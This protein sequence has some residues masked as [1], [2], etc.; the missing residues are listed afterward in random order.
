MKE[1]TGEYENILYFN[2]TKN[3]TLALL[4]A[5]N[6]V[7]FFVETDDVKKQRHFNVP[8]TF[9]NYEKS[10]VIEDLN[11][12]EIT[13]LNFNHL[14]RLVLSFEGITKNAERQTQKY[15]KFSKLIP[16][17][18]SHEKAQFAYN[19]L[20]Y[21]FSFKLLLQTRG[22][23]AATQIT[24]S[25]LCK[26]NPSLTLEIEEFPL[27]D[28]TETQIQIGDPEFE[29]L[30]EFETTDVNIVNVSFEILIRGNIYSPIG[31]SGN[32]E[33]IDLYLN[34]W[35]EKLIKDAK[36]A[37]YYRFDV[38]KD[39]IVSYT[40][41]HFDATG[42]GSY[43]GKPEPVVQGPEVDLIKER[44]DYHPYETKTKIK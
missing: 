7:P 40:E 37:S 13:S 18:V 26:F 28:L 27:L 12:N 31:L 2:S 25:I 39:R 21:D 14:P 15:Q 24:E 38:E 42:E 34:V 8:I 33:T 43:P 20:S 9:G 30:E 3:Y 44:P 4:D 32:I 36:L 6:S 11:E 23:T 41:R 22:L 29:I 17:G 10:L 35:Q 19:S 5:F 16:G 1:T